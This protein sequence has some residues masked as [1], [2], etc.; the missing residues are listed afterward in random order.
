MKI[1]YCT[2]SICYPGGIQTITIVKANALANIPGNEV[3]I[4]VTDN[5]QSPL[6]P[7]VGVKLVDLD[8][9]YFAD[10]W[11]GYFYVVKNILLK[12]R[13]HKKRLRKV[14]DEIQPDVVIS[15]GTSEKNFLPK[16][17]IKSNPICVREIHCEKKYRIKASS[18]WKWKILAYLGDWYDYGCMI[19][20][21]DKIAVL[22]Y[23]DKEC[24]WKGWNKV[25]VM[26]NPATACPDSKS[27]CEQKIVIAAGRLVQQKNFISLI[28]CWK[29]VV[30]RHPDWRLDI[31]GSGHQ[32][33]VLKNE[34]VELNLN[35]KVFLMGYSSD[36]Y[37]K[38]KEA[39]IYVLSSVFEGFPLVLIEAMSV[40]LPVVSYSCPTGPKDIVDDG[41]NGFLIPVN[42]EMKMAE[43]IC[44][45]IEDENL[46]K[47]MGKEAF[48]SSKKYK[49]EVIAEAWMNLFQQL[50]E[51]KKC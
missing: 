6:K 51:Q 4:V 46:R 7:L 13:I 23:E 18:D 1:V 2:D 38:M 20:Q 12:R 14:L 24:N 36:I 27:T 44:T 26:P 15:T 47:M 45:L 30:E 19:K 40:G 10:D 48:L 29:N 35:G 43:K 39:S 25:V 16:L 49:I 41:K 33:S 50:I 28:R 42:D 31:W 17:K 22:T 21:Y 8:V 9:N 32:E 37:G 5:K 34:I 11:K 3:W